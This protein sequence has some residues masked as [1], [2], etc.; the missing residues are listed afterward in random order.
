[1]V[2]NGDWKQGDICK[3]LKICV[4]R[5]NILR[6]RLYQ[7][8]SH[9]VINEI[10]NVG[11]LRQIDAH[12]ANMPKRKFSVFAFAVNNFVS[13]CSHR[14]YTIALIKVPKLMKKFERARRGAPISGRSMIP[15]NH[16]RIFKGRPA[17]SSRFRGRGARRSAD[18][19]Q[20]ATTA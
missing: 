5:L 17:K 13:L 20:H 9:L 1:M 14:T 8:R 2:K 10:N 15:K 19:A 12:L 7:G 6:V 18:P 11:D 16:A 3:V 4:D